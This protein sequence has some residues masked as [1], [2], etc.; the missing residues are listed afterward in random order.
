[1]SFNVQTAKELAITEGDVRT[2][3]DA[4]GNQLWGRL[5]YSTTYDGDTTQQTYTGYQLL[6][7]DGLATPIT[8]TDYW[9]P[10]NANLS[11]TPLSN[12][13]VRITSA[14]NTTAK[15]MFMKYAAFEWL[16]S[17]TYTIILEVKNAPNVGNIVLSQP[18]NAADP[19]QSVTGAS[20]I[21]FSGDDTTVVF[22]G[23]TKDTI[24]SLALRMF[25]G[26]T[27]SNTS[28]DLRLTII[29]GD[30]TSNYQNYCG[31]NYEP[32][33]GGTPAPN[34]DYPQ[35]VNVVTGTQT[36]S[37]S[38]GVNSQDFTVGL[39]S[40]NL[41]D[42]TP[43]KE[44]YY[45]GP[46][47][48]ESAGVGTCIY[49][50]I[51]TSPNTTYTISLRNLS[52][53]ATV[54]AHAYDENGNWI[55]QIDF[56][57]LST[58][59]KKSMTF[60]TPANTKYLRWS[61]WEISMTSDAQLE[62]G[63]TA[64]PYTPFY[65]YEL[66]KIGTYQDY[67]YKSGS[68][69]YVHKETGKVVLDGTETW[70]WNQYNVGNPKYARTTDYTISSQLAVNVKCTHFASINSTE[71]IVL[72][73]N[74]IRIQTNQI[75]FDFTISTQPAD[76]AGVL[77]WLSSNQPKV[78]YALAT[79]T[80]TQITDSTLIGQLNAIHEWLTRYGYNATVSGNLPLV[81]NQTNLA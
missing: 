18:Q 48:N 66:A 60:T 16:A 64:T 74:S 50:N 47:G 55:E 6:Q 7:K 12:N 42:T 22:S 52:D 29:A 4:D 37:I 26:S 45:I 57:T 5:A 49:G 24:S 75:D 77:S 20:Y 76:L 62:L 78:Y 68:D 1:M 9:N 44:G 58:N 30:H 51:E 3:H 38:D 39:T 43:Y 13:W 19:F 61:F 32:Y 8:D 40:K 23:V 27:F 70:T 33:V 79:A 53:Y 67:I 59:E 56:M 17:T 54:R 2:I 41:W 15:N 11:F 80:D 71:S 72:A 31:D 69:W 65:N 28:V 14:E 21:N 10:V 25:F 63:S 73:Q 46:N 34:P 36:V 35:A 81:I